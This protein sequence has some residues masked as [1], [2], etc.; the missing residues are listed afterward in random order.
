MARIKNNVKIENGGKLREKVAHPTRFELVTLP[1]EGS[2]RVTL[3]IL[4]RLNRH[5]VLG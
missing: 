1:S 3:T 4:S 5:V 2:V